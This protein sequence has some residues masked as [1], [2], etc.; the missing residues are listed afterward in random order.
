MKNINKLLLAMTGFV[1][2]CLSGCKHDE[3]EA[4]PMELKAPVI[5]AEADGD[6]A[7]VHW[8]P[9]TNAVS[10]KIECKKTTESN[11]VA[12][13]TAT[14]G[15][16]RIADLTYGNTY[17]IR[18]KATCDDIESPYSNVVS[19][20]I[21]RYLPKPLIRV[22]S[23]ITFLDVEWDAIEGAASYSVEHKVSVA[24]DWTVD[25]TGNLNT[26]KIAGL[27]SGVAY[28]VRV[29]AI[30]EGYSTSYSEVSTVTT[31]QA[32]STMISTGTQLAEWLSAISVETSD[33]AALANDIDMQGIT[34]T[35]ASGFAGTLEGQ[36]FA[37]KNLVSSVPLFAQN[38]G[39]IKD[40]VMDESCVFNAGD[41]VFGAFVRE[42]IGGIYKNVVNK[43]SVTYSA[44]SDVESEVILGGIAGVVTAARFENCTNEG[45]VTFDAPGCAH[46]VAAL[47]GLAGVVNNY[48]ANTTFYACINNGAITLNAKYGDPVGQFSFVPGNNNSIGINIAGI[49]GV[50]SY[51]DS[52]K[53]VFDE[54]INNGTI[55][56]THSDMS[57]LPA[58]T[59]NSGY[60]SLAGISGLG[61]ADFT[62]CRNTGLIKALALVG[63]V[64][65][66]EA[67]MKKK[68]YLLSIGGIGT[69]AWDNQYY[70]S[71]INSGNIEVEYY[72]L[73]DADDRWRASI[74]GIGARGARNY[75]GAHAHGCT[76]TGNITVSGK[77]TMAVGG[78][79]GFYGEQL[80]NTVTSDC[81]ITVNGRK[82]DIGGLVG[83]VEGKPQY[84][85]IKGCSC[86][87]TI[88]A[89]SDWG[90][91]GKTFYY[92]IGGLMG[93][94]SGANTDNYPGLT[95]NSTG[96]P[97]SFTGSVSSVWQD[98]RVGMV[99]G[100][101]GGDGKTKVFG[102]ETNPIKVSGTITRNE[103]DAT[104][105]TAENV[106]E[107][108]IGQKDGT[109]T[110]YVICSN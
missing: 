71:C 36:G 23:G 101:A 50:S 110:I 35:S 38:S 5:S 2:L 21:A 86:A 29:G 65:Q 64:D 16:H 40:I 81:H 32:P 89:D 96:V 37:I 59:N 79:Y 41:N 27:E 49:A 22:N 61:Q 11:F 66:S 105:I 9:V 14:Y 97:C 78:I 24:S 31:T 19:V 82:G 74:G 104:T 46:K 92:T 13:G 25:Y 100:R 93:R 52:S 18:V 56:L 57:V 103:L 58:D 20:D 30:A 99:V 69:V 47:G 106:E 6:A 51:S 12:V 108:A 83:Y 28:D 8:D 85:T 39:T 60:V 87:A 34:I 4:K 1:L 88:F 70:D 17:E 76:M 91:A 80:D 44:T 77:G 48:E 68:N 95:S 45:A 62:N 7:I 102:E 33:V 67:V 109:N 54:C 42:S 72:G 53:A 90:D 43:A 55:T 84:Y 75:D 98:G 26:Y 63:G 107:Y 73:Y 15:P 94:W 10:Y 3:P